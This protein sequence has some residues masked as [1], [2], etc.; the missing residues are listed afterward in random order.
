V[1]APTITWHSLEEIFVGPIV[2][3]R[4]QEIGMGEMREKPFQGFALVR[5][6]GP[7]LNY[8]VTSK[9]SKFSVGQHGFQH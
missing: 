6:N 3:G 4:K 2:S 1:Y 8:L 7:Y 5:P 9:R